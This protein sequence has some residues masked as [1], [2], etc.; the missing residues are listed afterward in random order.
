MYKFTKKISCDDSDKCMQNI[1]LKLETDFGLSL[2]AKTK[3]DSVNGHISCHH[4]NTKHT[5]W[6][7]IYSNS[8]V[9]ES[10]HG[11]TE[12]VIETKNNRVKRISGSLPSQK[13][14]KNAI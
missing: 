8:G 12:H 4:H 2:H 10:A 5:F 14:I 7:F 3:T 11:I 6:I 1:L 13:E 9:H